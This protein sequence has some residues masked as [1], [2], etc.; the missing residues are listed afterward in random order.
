MGNTGSSDKDSN[1]MLVH[2]DEDLQQLYLGLTELAL[3][4]WHPLHFYLFS[5]WLAGSVQPFI[6]STQRT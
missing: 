5:Y 4:V 3:F 1:S 2:Q 6:Q